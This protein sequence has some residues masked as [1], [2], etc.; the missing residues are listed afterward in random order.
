MIVLHAG[1]RAGF[2]PVAS[3]VFKAKSS[4]GDYHSEMNRSNFMKWLQE[5][6]IPNLS[7]K[8]ALVMNNAAYHNIQIDRCPTTAVRKAEI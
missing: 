1:S 7:Q 8:S 3:S 2:V 4:S 5:I 6:L